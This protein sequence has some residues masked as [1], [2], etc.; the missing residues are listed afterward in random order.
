MAE[1]NGVNDQV[2]RWQRTQGLSPSFSR[3]PKT[4]SPTREREGAR[5]PEC[6]RM[7]ADEVGARRPTAGTIRSWARRDG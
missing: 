3:S 2:L 5:I 6:S 1:T 7:S 4:R